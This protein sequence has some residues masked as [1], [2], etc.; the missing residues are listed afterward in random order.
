MWIEAEGFSPN[1]AVT[2]ELLSSSHEII[3]L[4]TAH[5]D[6]KGRVRQFVQTPTAAAG[7]ADVVVTGAAGNDD[8]V[9][10]LP[11]KVANARHQ[12]GGHILGFLRNCKCD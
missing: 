1:A 2:I 4:T 3:P 11:V 9:R 10:M 5:A 7:D 12:Y 6:K 8:L